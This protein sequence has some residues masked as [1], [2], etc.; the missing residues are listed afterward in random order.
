MPGQAVWPLDDSGVGYPG[1]SDFF[2]D[3]EY[4]VQPAADGLFYGRLFRWKKRPEILQFPE[5]RGNILY[6]K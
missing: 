6:L 4:I 1:F 2:P 5:Y 3:S